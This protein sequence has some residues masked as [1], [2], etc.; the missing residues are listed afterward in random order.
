V[1]DQAL[2]DPKRDGR[3]FSGIMF[4][5]F[6]FREVRAEGLKQRT[7]CYAGGR[8]RLTKPSINLYKVGEWE[9]AILDNRS[10]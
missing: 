7:T 9:H 2:S 1:E 10:K 4:F 6:T 3:K 8:R 5:I